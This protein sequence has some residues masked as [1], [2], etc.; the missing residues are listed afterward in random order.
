MAP[1]TRTRVS[2]L[3]M[4]HGQSRWNARNR[5]TG[6]TDVRLTPQGEREAWAAG[7]IIGSQKIELRH[8]YTSE[9]SR[10]K[11]TTELVLQSLE[12]TPPVETSWRLN[13]RHYGALT[14]LHKTETM[15]EMGAERVLAM[16]RG[17]LSPPLMDETHPMW[18]HIVGRKEAF[19]ASGELPRAESIPQA[20]ERVELFWRRVIMEKLRELVEGGRGGGLLV[21]S[22]LHTIRLLI[23]ELDGLARE[24]ELALDVPTAV[25][26]LYEVDRLDF[27]APPRKN[28]GSN[29]TLVKG[30]WLGE[31]KLT[32]MRISAIRSLL[33]RRRGLLYELLPHLPDPVQKIFM[34]GESFRREARD[35]ARKTLQTSVQV[36][37]SRDQQVA[38]LRSLFAARPWVGVVDQTFCDACARALH[39]V[40]DE[41][42]PRRKYDGLRSGWHLNNYLADPV[43]VESFPSFARLVAVAAYLAWIQNNGA[44]FLPPLE[45]EFAKDIAKKGLLSDDEILSD[46]APPDCAA[47]YP[48][49]AAFSEPLHFHHHHHHHHHHHQGVGNPSTPALRSL[50]SD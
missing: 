31:T 46:L 40:S 16:R 23:S 5:F 27:H 22:H 35:H 47:E 25:P 3:L 17:S 18:P 14:G 32:S 41:G 39:A 10:A 4:R 20:R 34:Q 37:M 1:P 49:A 42:P 24:A 21:V 50:T 45:Y 44:E 48:R 15:E 36:I 13:E 33:L 8:V 30:R 9:L 11:K 43:S 12:Q 38:A 28:D 19:F 7:R 29:V 6:W 2:L 26:L